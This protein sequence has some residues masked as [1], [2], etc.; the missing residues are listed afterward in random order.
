MNP[1]LKQME[2]HRSIRKYKNQDVEDHVIQQILECAINASSSGNMQAYSVIVTK[3]KEI[4]EAL[5]P[6]HFDQNMALEAPVFVTFCA[7]FNRTRKWLETRNAPLNF[8]NPMSFMI[9]AIDAILVSQNF[10]LAAESLGLGI[11]YLGTT[12]ANCHKIAKI[13]NCPHQVVPVVG[14]SLGHP[15]EGPLK[16][17]RLPSKFLFHKDRY[18][19]YSEDDLRDCYIEREKESMQ[20][21]GFA[22]LDEYAHFLTTK[23]YTKESHLLYSQNIIQCLRDQNYLTQ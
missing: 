11:C 3:K 9:G 5:S 13:L 1:V 20:R 21:L 10:S 22:K 7:D 23:K 14:M 17:N 18:Q 12:L 2:Q 4:R 8:D 6:L 16:R 19:D 15:A